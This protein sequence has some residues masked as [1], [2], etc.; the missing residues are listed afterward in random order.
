MT[1][2]ARLFGEARAHQRRRRARFAWACAAGLACVLA[3]WIATGPEVPGARPSRVRTPAVAPSAVFVRAPYLGVRCPL[4]N[5][6]RCDRVGLAIWL[7][8]PAVRVRGTVAGQ[9]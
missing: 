5:S 8:R 2:I 7:R 4:A 9:P 1:A 3:A 6:I